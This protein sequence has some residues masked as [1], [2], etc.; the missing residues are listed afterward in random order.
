LTPSSVDGLIIYCAFSPPFV[1][2]DPGEKTA[3]PDKRRPC[4]NEKKLTSDQTSSFTLK[5]SA[6]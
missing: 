5:S 1:P 2:P 4:C 6:C 3:Y